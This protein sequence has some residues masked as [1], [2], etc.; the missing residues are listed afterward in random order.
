MR[1]SSN[2]LRHRITLQ[3]QSVANDGFGQAQDVWIDVAT[4]WASIEPS[5]KGEQVAGA[6]MVASR[7]HLVTL[8][9]RDGVTAKMRALFGSRIFEIT[10][11]IDVE[12]RHFWLQLDCT[13]GLTAG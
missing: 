2:Q 7:T 10:S 13:E 8:R 4:C 12:E 5:P 1:P 3:S 9:Y 6:A 11:V